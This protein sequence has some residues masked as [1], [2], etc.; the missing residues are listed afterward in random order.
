MPARNTKVLV[1]LAL[2]A[3]AV[4]LLIIAATSRSGYTTDYYR[5]PTEFLSHASDYVNLT[6]R[7]NGKVVPG[8]IRRSPVSAENGMPVL[9]FLLGDSLGTIPVRYVGT[10][11]PDA[12]K[13]SADVVVEGLY[14]AD[15]LVQARQLLVK[16]P[17]KYE[18][19]PTEERQ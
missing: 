2:A 9:D 17:S 12:F 4:A 16:C 10:T 13:E 19:T 1:S 3:G 5:T 7:V 14:T 11:V 6:I 18:A 15:G 8:S